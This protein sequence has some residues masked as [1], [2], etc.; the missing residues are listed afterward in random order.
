MTKSGLPSA[1]LLESKVKAF[2]S[3]MFDPPAFGRR[4][5]A[6]DY[7]QFHENNDFEEG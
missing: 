5:S 7:Q 6:L 1:E 2:S 3:G 4:Q